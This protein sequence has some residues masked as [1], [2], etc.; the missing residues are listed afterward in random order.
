MEIIQS[1][2][3]ASQTLA[4]LTVSVAIY[5]LSKFNSDDRAVRVS[6][7]HKHWLDDFLGCPFNTPIVSSE[8]E[9]Y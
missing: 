4:R 5:S 2:S 3:L 8:S 1:V 6:V 9:R 7:S